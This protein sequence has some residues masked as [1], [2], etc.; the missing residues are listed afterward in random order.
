MSYWAAAQ[1]Q[2]SRERLA[3]HCLSVVTGFEVY[4][5]RIKAP[6]AR[7]EVGSALGFLPICDFPHLPR[8]R[9]ARGEWRRDQ[10]PLWSALRTQVGHRPRS[11][12]C[13]TARKLSPGNFGLL[14]HGV[15]PGSCHTKAQGISSPRAHEAI[16]MWPRKDGEQ[17]WCTMLDWTCR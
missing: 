5:P 16:L 14:Q 10:C 4:S 12:K 6:Q 7:R 1:L 2:A 11:E 8:P 3:L 9:V 13:L 15:I 17:Q